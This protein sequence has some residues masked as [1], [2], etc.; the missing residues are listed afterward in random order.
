MSIEIEFEGSKSILTQLY[1]GNQN[2]ETLLV[3][4][5]LIG[6]ECSALLTQ[7]IGLRIDPSLFGWLLIDT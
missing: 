4:I 5:I 2:P 6:H 1:A 7:T 3:S